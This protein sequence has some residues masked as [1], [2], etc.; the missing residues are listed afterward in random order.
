MLVRPEDRGA[1]PRVETKRVIVR[2]AV[3]VLGAYADDHDLG[4]QPG[5]A[6]S[7]ITVPGSVMARLVHLNGGQ[8]IGVALQPPGPEMVLG[9]ASQKRP[10]GTVLDDQSHRVIVVPHARIPGRWNHMEGDAVQGEGARF[11]VKQLCPGREDRLHQPPVGLGCVWNPVV[12]E[13]PWREGLDCARQS[14]N[15]IRVR[16]RGDHHLQG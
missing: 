12:H 1:N 5:H 7:R 13:E 9:I 11:R 6:L 3:G 2:V 16:V 10:E 4:P 14:T 8:S 15:M